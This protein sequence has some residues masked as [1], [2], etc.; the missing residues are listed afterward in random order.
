[1][2]RYAP[3]T[4]SLRHITVVDYR[5]L[6]SVAPYPGLLKKISKKSGRN[7][8][9]RITVRHQGGGNKK[10]Y[11]MIDFR[12]NKKDIP[13]KVLSLEY[14]PFRT[15]F[16]ALVRYHDGERRYILA[17]HGLNVNDSVITSE[18]APFTPGNR[19]ALHAIPPGTPVH[20][21]ELEPERGGS[22]I[23]SAGSY[24]EILG[25]DGR[26]THL[27]LPSGEVRMVLSA[28]FASI[29][30]LSNPEHNLTTHG[31]AG[32]TRHRGVRPTVRG[33][34]MNPRDH[35]YGGG[36]GRQSRGTRRPKDKWGKITGGV[37]T[38]RKNKWSNNLIISRRKK[39]KK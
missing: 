31:K 3:K 28:S 36:E 7:H 29:G 14:D 24:A 8:S 27:K 15:A 26:Y 11:R 12:Q 2:K 18:I 34:V 4:P 39:K 20:N 13:G 25:H 38:R 22:L 1:M 5:G 19:M 9:G 30:P 16:I 35:P 17:P 23:R 37:K 6:S 32:K 21:I 10:R 33:S